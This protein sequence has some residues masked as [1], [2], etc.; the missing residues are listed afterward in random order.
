M[1]L[2]TFYD[3]RITPIL[4]PNKDNTKKKKKKTTDTYFM[5]INTQSSEN[6]S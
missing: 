2:S 4:K 3:T 5:T 6:I 1:P